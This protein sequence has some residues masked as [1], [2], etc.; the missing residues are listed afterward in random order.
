MAS[1]APLLFCPADAAEPPSLQQQR[2]SALQL[3]SQLQRAALLVQQQDDGLLGARGSSGGVGGSLSST[4]RTVL[5]LLESNRDV[6]D[7]MPK[8][9]CQ[10]GG[11]LGLACS[12]VLE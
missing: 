1:L 3:C 12:L 6:L 9:I 8:V 11:G 4:A 5:S 10:H 7:N 2:S